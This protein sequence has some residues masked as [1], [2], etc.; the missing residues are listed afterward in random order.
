M[1]R[2]ISQLPDS[3]APKRFKQ[4]HK[5]VKSSNAQGITKIDQKISHADS[6]DRQNDLPKPAMAAAEKKTTETHA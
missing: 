6:F 2:T 1:K 5:E 3:E 4:I